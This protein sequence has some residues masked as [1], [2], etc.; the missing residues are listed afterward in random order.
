M[1]VTKLQKSCARYFADLVVFFKFMQGKTEII[2][3]HA[4]ENKFTCD[5]S[6]LALHLSWM[7]STPAA[8]RG[9]AF[10]LASF[11]DGSQRLQH[12][13]AWPFGTVYHG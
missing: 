4:F 5:I 11:L 1:S 8:S 9:S 3:K 2:L 10:G 6:L 13:A 12:L 7:D